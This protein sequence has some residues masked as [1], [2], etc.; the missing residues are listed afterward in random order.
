MYG[1]GGILRCQ[2][3][4]DGQRDPNPMRTAVL[5]RKLINATQTRTCLVLVFAPPQSIFPDPHSL[6]ELKSMPW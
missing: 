3:E 4:E 6:T 1:L 5:L 2:I